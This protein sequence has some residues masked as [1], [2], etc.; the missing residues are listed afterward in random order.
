MTR[1]TKKTDRMA[2]F[3]MDPGAFISE[4]QGM[5]NQQ[6]GIYARLLMLYWTI[7]NQLPVNQAS[8]K[9]RLSVTSPEEELQ[10]EELLEEF[11]PVGEDGIRRNETLDGRLEDVAQRSAQASANAYKRYGKGPSVTPPTPKSALPDDDDF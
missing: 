5:T 7:G 1:G 10:L 3:K 6:V 8:L 4:T 11:F 2:W 9:R